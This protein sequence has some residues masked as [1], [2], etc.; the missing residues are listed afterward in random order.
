MELQKFKIG[1]TIIFN[2][3]F[4]IVTIQIQTRCVIDYIE[5]ENTTISLYGW[6]ERL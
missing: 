6:I 4:K 5:K 3:I 1:S 2:N